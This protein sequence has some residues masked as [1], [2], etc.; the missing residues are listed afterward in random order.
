VHQSP[1]KGRASSRF[2]SQ[3]FRSSEGLPQILS[4]GLSKMDTA[5]TARNVWIFARP[6]SGYGVF[7]ASSM[8]AT[9]RGY[10][11]LCHWGVLVTPLG[12]VDIKAIVLRDRKG[13]SNFDDFELGGMWELQRVP[14]DKNTVNASRPFRVSALKSLWA[15]FSGQYI[16]PTVFTDKAIQLEGKILRIR[17]RSKLNFS[18]ADRKGASR[19]RTLSE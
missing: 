7:P 14:D 1:P 15:T 8:A 10:F 16:G 6:L 5:S 17:P 12:I 3:L 11:H 18:V 19:L 4:W 2:K 9:S 13:H